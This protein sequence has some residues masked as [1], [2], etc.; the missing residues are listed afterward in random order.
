MIVG[1]EEILGYNKEKCE[2]MSQLKLNLYQ[3]QS[4]DRVNTSSTESTHMC[5]ENNSEDT[6]DTCC[7]LNPCPHS[8]GR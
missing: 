2:E 6:A 1:Y 5:R 3:G 7:S 8:Q 4:G